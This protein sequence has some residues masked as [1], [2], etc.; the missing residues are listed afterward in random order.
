MAPVRY[1]NALAIWEVSTYGQSILTNWEC[2]L[3][4][5]DQPTRNAKER[6]RE[7][8]LRQ[9]SHPRPNLRMIVTDAERASWAHQAY[10]AEMHQRGWAIAYGPVADAAGDYG[11]GF[12]EVPDDSRLDQRGRQ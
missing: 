5:M 4:V 7:V 12:W 9:A 6:G 8:L 3:Q 2:G 1:P 11:A 10:L